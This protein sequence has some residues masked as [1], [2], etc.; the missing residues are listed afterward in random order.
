[1]T[2]PSSSPV[3]VSYPEPV[4]SDTLVTKPVTGRKRKCLDPEEAAAR[5]AEQNRLAQKAFRERKDL[6][7]KELEVKVAVLTQ[8][9]ASSSS[10][11][12]INAELLEKIR[13]LEERCAGLER[14]NVKLKDVVSKVESQATPPVS[15]PA[16]SIAG[17][18]LPLSWTSAGVQLPIPSPSHLTRC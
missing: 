17:Y 15:P 3:P 9:T 8:L 6:R 4:D 5:K 16:Q 11:N 2:A 1:M 12:T 13:I 10:T 7:I 14:E 18:Q